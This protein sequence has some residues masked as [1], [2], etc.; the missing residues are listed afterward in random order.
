MTFPYIMENKKWLKP[1]TSSASIKSSC[2]IVCPVN[3]KGSNVEGS[4]VLW[5]SFC[6]SSFPQLPKDFIRRHRK[7]TYI[8][9]HIY[10]HIYI[11]IYIYTY[12]RILYIYTYTYIRIL[13]IYIYGIW[14]DHKIYHSA[15]TFDFFPASKVKASGTLRSPK[16]CMALA[17]LNLRM[18]HPE[19]KQKKRLETSQKCGENGGF[20]VFFFLDFRMFSRVEVSYDLYHNIY[21][22][23]IEG[24]FWGYPMQVW[25]LVSMYRWDST[26]FVLKLDISWYIQKLPFN[27]WGKHGKNVVWNHAIECCL[28]DALG[29]LKRVSRHDKHG[30]ELQDFEEEKLD[31][32]PRQVRFFV[33]HVF[34]KN[35]HYLDDDY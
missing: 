2:I 7:L 25:G 4:D 12:I 5:T 16:R 17:S 23:V 33:E 3:S 19:P 9:T 26:G 29:F 13:Y 27:C 24:N 1:P 11:Y 21:I 30:V 34:V 22:V 15:Y 20:Y 14:D 28:E 6:L 31:P 8:Y 32:G 18:C 10:I 35:N